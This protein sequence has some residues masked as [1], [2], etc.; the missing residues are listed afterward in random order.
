MLNP[1]TLALLLPICT[2]TLGVAL[3]MVGM[4]LHYRKRKDLFTLYH[5]ERMAAIDKGMEL[6]PLPEGILDEQAAPYN[7]RRHLLKGLAWLFTG[8]GIGAGVFAT[9]GLDW[10]WFSLVPIGVGAAHLI[11]YA[12]EGRREAGPQ[13]PSRRATP[14]GV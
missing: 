3:A 14:A 9:V 4:Y 11:Y 10:A 7:P 2:I 12:V 13:E 8:I 5:Q 1:A 6:P